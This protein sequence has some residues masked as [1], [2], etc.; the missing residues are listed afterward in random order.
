MKSENCSGTVIS[1]G[2]MP[3]EKFKRFGSENLT[4]SE[5]LAIILRT[6]T[7]DLNVV[8]LSKA[9][10]SQAGSLNGLCRMDLNSLMAFKGIGEVKAIRIKCLAELSCRMSREL[11]SGGLIFQ[12]PSSVA[13]YYMESLRH[14]K[15]ERVILLLLDSKSMLLKEM[16]LSKGTINV[17]L[18]S[19]REILVEALKV[20]AVAILILHNHPSGDSSP[21]HQDLLITEKV[22]KSAELLDVELVDHI[23]IGDKQYFSF[24]EANLL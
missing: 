18:I 5:L 8:D 16:V 13:D 17:S 19:P 9:I 12:S 3:Y 14:E 11:A 6:G 24:R 15:R 2:E 22:Q 21:S 20:D 23:I 1:S 10:L 4:E 7:H